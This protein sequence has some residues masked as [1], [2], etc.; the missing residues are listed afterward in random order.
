MTAEVAI[1]AL[2]GNSPAAPP[3]RRLLRERSAWLL[4]LAFLSGFTFIYTYLGTVLIL[5]AN[6]SRTG[7]PQE[8]FIEAT[9]RSMAA[10]ESA[11]ALGAPISSRFTRMFPQV[12]DGLIEPLWPWLAS[13]FAAAPP[14]ALFEKG[15]WL[16]LILSCSVLLAMG[17]AAARAFSFTGAAAMLLMGGFGIVLERSAYFSPDALY[18]LLVLLT[19]LCA[20]S[21][22]R[23]NHLWLYGVFG[24]LLGLTYLTKTPI[25]PTVLAFA[26]TSAI[27]SAA[28]GFRPARTR[29]EGP[30]DATWSASNQL[31][32]FAML[33]TVFLLVAGPRLSYAAT[34]F[35]APFHS[36]ERYFVW[37]DSP[38]EASRFRAA[39]S[40]KEELASLSPETRPGLARYLRENGLRSLAERSWQGALAE[41]KSSAL[42]RSG[43]ILFYA[44]F[45]FLAIAAIHRWTMWKQDL[46]I[47]RV[48]GTSARWMLLFSLLAGGITLFHVGIGH[49]VVKGNLMTTS[50]FLPGV[51]TFIWIAE[52]YRRQL[53]RS[54]CA[55]LA[56]A[57]YRTLMAL[58]ILY[59]GFRTVEA[60]RHVAATPLPGSPAAG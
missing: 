37:L 3:Q 53:Q 35:G 39:H 15:K 42:G 56:N 5:E 28:E 57:T 22:I 48:R 16:N 49:P 25:W 50:L 41:L 51:M 36:Y 21:L 52:R 33:A 30:P 11:V 46:E 1:S 7:N 6:T 40:G 45:V 59:V 4:F 14:D 8:S 19:W 60:L 13:A 31:V 10:R 44:L 29:I 9:Y 38:Q 18:C 32:G 12:T 26:L 55:D 54:R 58:P 20:L 17:V 24:G 27:R 43:W 2:P 34:E 23:Q 47:W